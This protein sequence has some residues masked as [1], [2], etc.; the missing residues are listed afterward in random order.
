MKVFLAYSTFFINIVINYLCYNMALQKHRSMLINHRNVIKVR[1]YNQ[2]LLSSL[3]MLKGLYHPE[4][5]MIHF[6]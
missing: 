1:L 5:K 3:L 4:T 6:P 2:I